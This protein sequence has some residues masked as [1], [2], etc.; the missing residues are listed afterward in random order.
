MASEF[1]ATF[2]QRISDYPEPVRSALMLP[3]DE[4]LLHRYL[5]ILHGPG[6]LDSTD[7]RN[8]LKDPPVVDTFLGRQFLSRAFLRRLKS[9]TERF[10]TEGTPANF[11]TL[12]DDFVAPLSDPDGPLLYKLREV[13]QTPPP[14]H[15]EAF[16]ILIAMAEFHARAGTYGTEAVDCILSEMLAAA[17]PE[18]SGFLPCLLAAFDAPPILRG[19]QALPEG[20]SIAAGTTFV[21]AVLDGRDMVGLTQSDIDTLALIGR[22]HGDDTGV[23]FLDAPHPLSVVLDT[24]SNDIV[25]DHW[26]ALAAAGAI[27]EVRPRGAF[28]D[29]KATGSAVLHLPAE[30][31]VS[32]LLLGYLRCICSDGLDLELRMPK[33][34]GGSDWA[35]SIKGYIDPE[36][37]MPVGVVQL[38]TGTAPMPPLE[39]VSPREDSTSSAGARAAMDT[40]YAVIVRLDEAVDADRYTN[41][42]CCLVVD[43]LRNLAA[44][45]ADAPSGLL[46]KP[47]VLLGANTPARADYLVE[48][49]QEYWAFGGR[50]PVTA[51]Q[52]EY[53]GAE[54]RLRTK[55]ITAETLTHLAMAQL[56][57]LPLDDALSLSEDQLVAGHLL[58]RPEGMV[59]QSPGHAPLSL[60]EVIPLDRAVEALELSDAERDALFLSSGMT[61]DFLK[62]QSTIAHWPIAHLIRRPLRR[63][64][65]IQ[66][67]FARF[68][69][70]PTVETANALLHMLARNSPAHGSKPDLDRFALHLSRHPRTVVTLDEESLATYLTLVRATPSGDLIAQNLAL[71]TTEIC[72]GNPRHIIPFFELMASALPLAELHALLLA[73]V[74]DGSLKQRNL[75][76][77]GE[78]LR[79]YGTPQINAHALARLHWVRSDLHENREF[80]RFF[81][82]VMTHD[83]PEALIQLL[84]ETVLTSIAET[85]EFGDLFLEA[86]AEGER[87]RLI[88]LLS[89][90]ERGRKVEFRKW[91]DT[92]R[93]YSNELRALQLPVRAST[94]PQLNSVFANKLMAVIFSDTGTLGELRN[95]ALLEEKN[96]I[97]LVAQ[98]ILGRN[99]AL[100]SWLVESF[101]GSELPPLQIDG[102][103]VSR[104]FANAA[105]ATKGVRPRKK[106]PVV[107]VILSVYNP[108]LGLMKLALDSIQSQNYQPVEIFVI[109]DASTSGNEQA[110]A[111]LC[112]PYKNVTLIR[113]EANAG[114][115]VGRNLALEQARGTFIAIHDC[116]DWA[117]PA[118]LSAQVAAFEENHFLQLVTCPHIRI[119]QQGRVQLESGFRILGDG[120]MTS[121]FRREVFDTLGPF[122]NVRS[123]GDVEMRERIRDYYGSHALKE[124]QWPMM[125]CFA[126]TG[127]LSQTTK[128]GKY[129]H[130][131]LFRGNISGRTG[132]ADL[133]RAGTNVNT[134]HRISVPRALRPDTEE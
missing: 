38:G 22:D 107:S 88:A 112:K 122:A 18:G 13:A 133:R 126:D 95:N 29:Q 72:R 45:L 127:T 76:R 2:M 48:R 15:A 28:Q 58:L 73:A 37:F 100:N 32:P 27:A 14:D 103:T 106:G 129:Q 121:M 89:D 1:S 56:C 57:V 49:V 55:P 61:T 6:P 84:G 113:L 21:R 85:R 108:D 74:S 4:T 39:I 34:S 130:L 3:L 131:Q 35:Q 19:S 81:Q 91:L 86:L 46:Q 104:V 24:G 96:D 120:P 44:K 105:Q 67:L 60:E 115:Y 40:C 8:L 123:R 10:K 117:H 50:Y 62:D 11:R 7:V 47:V 9:T 87:T 69:E 125:L 20:M 59:V 66:S 111:A 94:L 41:A 43:G 5:G 118:R 90:P 63:Q 102:D 70:Q 80:L 53:D 26:H 23:A 75:F 83:T 134:D 128:A 109:D 110:I 82:N 52:L 31:T 78:C 97:N 101:E 98:N 132:L 65:R 42:D 17:G 77:L 30:Q 114:P 25:P 93:G 124:L 33:S 99:A 51:A 119:D 92:L 36:L 71:C 16:A 68:D 64:A 12:I 116:D 79:R 54:S